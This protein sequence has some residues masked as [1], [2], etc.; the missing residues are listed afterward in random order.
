VLDTLW[1]KGRVATT[2]DF[3][4]FD[5]VKLPG[6]QYRVAMHQRRIYLIACDAQT[7]TYITIILKG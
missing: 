7:G 1:A 4:E 3:T 6:R 5:T 2:Q